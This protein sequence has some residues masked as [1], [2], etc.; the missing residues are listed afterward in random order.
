MYL[1][2]IWE[3]IPSNE[4]KQ[5][6][7][8]ILLNDL[9]I[10]LL[11][12]NIEIL[13]VGCGDG[14]SIDL[15]KKSEIQFNWK[16]LDIESSPEVRSRARTDGEFYSYD[17]INI[18]FPDESFDIVFSNQ[19]FEHVRYPE[20]V[21]REIRRVLKND[22]IFF[23][24]VSYLKPFHS[25]SLFNFTPY[26]WYTINKSCGLQPK[27]LAGGV[28]A[29]SLIKRNLK[30]DGVSDDMWVC[31]PL[32]KQIINDPSLNSKEKNYKILMGAGHI[33]F[34]CRRSAR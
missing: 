33:V 25:Y 4:A 34:M 31:S 32:N 26:G 11:G 18:P 13:D 9:S 22:G 19:V 27:F 8:R 21:L 6:N 5:F 3:C 17:G 7:V 10:N 30:M 16:G 24:S 14:K 2:E 28:D 23:G 1:K 15:F 20:I 12:R 29:V